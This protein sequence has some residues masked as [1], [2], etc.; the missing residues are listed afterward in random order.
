[1]GGRYPRGLVRAAL[2]PASAR[3]KTERVTVEIELRARFAETKYRQLFDYFEQHA[4]DL[5]ANDKHIYFYVLP[6]RLL[7]VVDN[8]STG[9]AKVSLK[10]NR[11][12]QG[13]SFPEI[14]MEIDRAQVGTAV[15][16]FNDLGFKD[17]MHDAFNCR[18]DFRYQGVEIAL[19]HSEA[20]GHHAE[21]EVLLDGDPS[22]AQKIQAA[23]R[24]QAVAEQLGV[25]LMTELELTEFTQ[26][27]ERT[28]A[29]ARLGTS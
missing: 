24:I 20:W 28:Q 18:H 9:T 19:K 3:E 13:S 1:M 22:E 25:R 26:E 29:A 4:V 7:K 23:A 14:E 11:L 6:D 15:Q 5:G 12:G 10:N 8:I 27:F 16:I 21:F 17:A 2:R